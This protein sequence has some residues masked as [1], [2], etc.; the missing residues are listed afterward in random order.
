[1]KP[2]NSLWSFST[3]HRVPNNIYNWKVFEGDENIISFLTNQDNFKDL[4]I[5]DEEFQV[6]STETDP[7]M[8]RPMDK[9]K[10]HMIS[11]GIANI[12]NIFDLKE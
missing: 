2:S 1:M 7:R 5:D 10:G 8:R 6:L 9:S 11:K 3:N 12:E 4:A